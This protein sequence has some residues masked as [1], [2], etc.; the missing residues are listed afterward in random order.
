MK[1]TAGHGSTGKGG[2]NSTM[3]TV[4]PPQA[5]GRHHCFAQQPYELLQPTTIADQLSNQTQDNRKQK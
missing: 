5:L 1:K 2:S 4:S 3:G